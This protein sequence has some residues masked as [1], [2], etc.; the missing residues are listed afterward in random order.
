MSFYQDFCDVL[1]RRRAMRELGSLQK[2]ASADGRGIFK[3]FMAEAH[4]AFDRD[5]R[6]RAAQIWTQAYAKFPDLAMFSP[7]AL[8]LL[9]KLQ[10]YDEAELIMRRGLTKHKREVHFLEGLATVAYQRGDWAEAE[11]RSATLRARHPSNLKGYWIAAACL[12]QLGRSKEAEAILGRGLTMR[13]DDV[14]LRIEFARLA[15]RRQD[16]S[17]AIARWTDVLDVHGHLAGAIGKANVLTQ[18]QR[19]DDADAVLDS[20]LHKSGNQSGV[21]IQ[22]AHVAESRPDWAAAADRWERFRMR[23]PLDPTGYIRGVV[24]LEKL[25]KHEAADGIVA[26][27]MER[28]PDDPAIAVEFA[29]LAHRRENWETA[30]QRWSHVRTRFPTRHEAFDL[31]RQALEALGRTDE[32]ADLR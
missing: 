19:Y 5:L 10:L 21:W 4:E 3:D 26:E 32:A 2:E 1:T 23:F 30:V 8:E 31:A 13:P 28:I 15:E 12:S 24:P 14:G 16:W 27:G 25:R 20:V 7:S 22:Y 17:E 9:L 29:L 11:K 6:G 18:L